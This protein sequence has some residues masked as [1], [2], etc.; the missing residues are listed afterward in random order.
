MKN[1][2]L[3]AFVGLFSFNAASSSPNPYN[4]SSDA[5]QL[6]TNLYVVSNTG[7]PVLVDGTLTQYSTDFSNNLDGYDARK[8]TNPGFNWGMLRSNHVYI[9][10]RRHV[11]EGA[12]SVFFKMWGMQKLNYRLEIITNNLTFPGRSGVLEDSYLKTSTPVS[13]NGN[14]EID[15]SVDGTAA[16]CAADRFRIIFSNARPA[17]LLPV[18]IV[19]SNAVQNNNSVDL[20][21]QAENAVNGNVFSI[22][23]STDGINFHNTQSVKVSSPDAYQFRVSDETPA[24]G[25]NYYRICS[26]DNTGKVIMY[27]KVMKVNVAT[28]LDNISIYPNPATSGN[29]NVKMSHQQAGEYT[30]SLLNSFGQKFMDKKV[31]YNGG[32]L[33][34]K[35]EPSQKIP[36][37]IYQLE[38]KSRDG[39]RKTMSVVF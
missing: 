21:W 10:E 2:Y 39:K 30:I 23:K 11:I 15:F 3:L 18:D 24:D 17:G 20:S 19:F 7:S 4:A 26:L 37:G 29:L 6:V 12:D 32:T 27:S 16:S 9:V 35:I 34:Q 33:I 31:Q 38:I 13:L 36:P 22:Q 5:I 8:M 1:F 25:E 28:V 14:T